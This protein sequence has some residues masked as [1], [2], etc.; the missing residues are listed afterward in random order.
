MLAG[1]ALAEHIKI[2]DSDA[3]IVGLVISKDKAGILFGIDNP[4]LKNGAEIT[5]IGEQKDGFAH[6][7]WVKPMVVKERIEDKKD[8]FSDITF[9]GIR[10]S[11]YRLESGDGIGV[12]Q[13]LGIVGAVK[14]QEVS[15]NLVTFDLDHDGTPEY[16][17]SCT[18]NEGVNIYLRS[19]DAEKFRDRAHYYYYIFGE[20][21][22]E[23]EATCKR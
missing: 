18:G 16:L 15:G 22:Y 12:P 14:T 13:G 1:S 7:Q 8:E 2:S 11:L 4:N 10:L 5:V 20:L 23:I 19:G 21:G 17:F 6:R 9:Q 3:K